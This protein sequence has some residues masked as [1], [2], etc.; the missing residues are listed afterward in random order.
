LGQAKTKSKNWYLKLLT[1]RRTYALTRARLNRDA[2]ITTDDLA[3]TL[4]LEQ[5]RKQEEAAID[6]T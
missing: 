6:A 3:E 4:R 2:P 5:E 1:S